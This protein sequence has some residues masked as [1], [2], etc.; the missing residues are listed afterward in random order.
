MSFK[1]QLLENPSERISNGD[2]IDVFESA[3]TGI[4]DPSNHEFFKHLDKHLK[5][6]T[7]LLPQIDLTGFS[8]E[9][10][11]HSTGLEKA[12]HHV[13]EF[14]GKHHQTLDEQVQEKVVEHMKNS[15]E[16]GEQAKYKA[17]EEE[18]KAM[19]KYK[20]DVHRWGM[21]ATI[22]SGD[23]PEPP[24]CPMHELVQ[25]RAREQEK[26]ITAEVRSHMTPEQIAKVDADAK[27]YAEG[28]QEAHTI[29]NPLGTGEGFKT[30]P[31]P[32]ADLAKYWRLIQ[33]QTDIDTFH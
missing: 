23:Y 16:P 25:Q 3:R 5:D 2:K 30:P 20:D 9:S 10:K 32:S 7:G 4:Y 19:Q 26:K 6:V 29:H 33:E 8:Q 28:V 21:Q 24:K 15:K 12:W 18:E 1:Q 13:Q 11:D 14:F 22:L 17:Y 27:K 31:P